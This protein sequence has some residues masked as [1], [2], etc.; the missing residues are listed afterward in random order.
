MVCLHSDDALIGKLL[1]ERFRAAQAD[2]QRLGER[3]QVAC[4]VVCKMV[5]QQLALR[6]C[7]QRDLLATCCGSSYVCGCRTTDGTASR[8]L[9]SGQAILHTLE[10][11][12]PAQIRLRN[13]FE[14]TFV[15]A[16]I[17]FLSS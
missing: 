8:L 15:G 9:S 11:P 1:Q 10:I 16:E 17:A 14:M 6:Q 12:L 2:A 13:I 7:A 5:D 4:G 3:K